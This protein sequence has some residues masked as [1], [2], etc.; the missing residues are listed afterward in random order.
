AMPNVRAQLGDRI[1]YA[2]SM[3]DALQGAD[4]LAVMTEWNEFRSPDFEQLKRLLQEPVIFDGRN[5]YDLDQM[6]G[7]GFHYESIG[8]PKVKTRKKAAV[9][10][11]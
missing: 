2:D 8:R 11:G 4:C 10:K 9:E 1:R 5:L 6:K 7:L 3:Y